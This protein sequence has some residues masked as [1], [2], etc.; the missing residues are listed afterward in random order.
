MT[1]ELEV[2]TWAA[3]HEAGHAVAT[4]LRGGALRSVTI[5]PTVEHWGLTDGTVPTLSGTFAIHAGPWA[6]ARFRW[7]LPRQE[8]DLDDFSDYVTRV[9]RENVAGD[10]D[11]ALFELAREQEEAQGI[12]YSYSDREAQWDRELEQYWPVIEAVA[13]LLLA[14]TTVDGDAVVSLFEEFKPRTK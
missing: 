7:P 8:D 9:W 14:E 3:H 2:R 5:D 1:D 11:S 12:F 6:E 10:G 13:A 4:L